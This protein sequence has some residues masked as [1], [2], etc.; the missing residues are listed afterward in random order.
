M[1]IRSGIRLFFYRSSHCT[2]QTYLPAQS[3]TGSFASPKSLSCRRCTLVLDADGG[4]WV[5]G[6]STSN[7]FSLES[8]FHSH[9]CCT[10]AN[11]CTTHIHDGVRRSGRIEEG[12]AEAAR[13]ST[14]QVSC[15]KHAVWL[16]SS[17]AAIGCCTIACGR[18][19]GRVVH[20]AAGGRS[21][22][23]VLPVTTFG[24]VLRAC[25]R[26]RLWI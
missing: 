24:I 5:A 14:C 15:G 1:I 10:V 13:Q 16:G 7:W 11:R 25:V 2:C 12:S 19:R 3:R 17:V 26:A 22:G 6:A 8:A 23:G 4:Y 9:T 18:N 21:H 20:D